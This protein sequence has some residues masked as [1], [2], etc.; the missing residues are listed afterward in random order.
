MMMNTRPA[1]IGDQGTV[2]G[3]ESYGSIATLLLQVG[4]DEQVYLYGD[5]RMVADLVEAFAG[6][7]VEVVEA[8]GSAY[9]A[10]SIRPLDVVIL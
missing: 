9:G 8:E 3:Q 2:V 4:D 5:W 1:Q 10:H 6:E 7:R